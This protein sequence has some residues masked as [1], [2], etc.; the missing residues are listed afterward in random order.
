ME[1]K[2]RIFKIERLETGFYSLDRAFSTVGEI[3][4]PLNVGW[5]LFGVSHIGKTTFAVSL[6]ALI[7]KELSKDIAF[8]D[9]EGIDIDRLKA[10]LQSQ[11]FDGTI[12]LP[13]ETED[14]KMLDELINNLSEPFIG[15]G[16]IDSLAA[17]SP[18]AERAGQLGEM[19]MGRR[20]MLIAK[21]SR[22]ILPIMRDSD[23]PSTLFMINHWVPMI[24]KHGYDTPGGEVKKYI[25]HER[26][27]L[28]IQDTFPDRSYW[29]KGE[30]YK[31][32]KGGAGR[33]KKEMGGTFHVVIRAN[34]GLHRNLSTMMDCV[35]AGKVERKKTL[36]VKETSE[37]LGF[38]K[39][40]FENAED[41]ERFQVFY[42]LL[43]KENDTS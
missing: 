16:I 1:I 19:N 22:K 17:I 21:L 33:M 6:S 30:V 7:A 11:D 34:G 43:G 25:T 26:V 2:G 37:S 18:I 23:N 35:V 38:L 40:Y 20:A 36:K 9:F 15:V 29:I 28:S 42:E 12:W 14:E 32:K 3:G 41:D 13:T 31:D 5:E 39:T 4:I 27:K 10:L 24:G 8:C